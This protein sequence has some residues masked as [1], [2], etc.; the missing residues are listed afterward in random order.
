MNQGVESLADSEVLSRLPQLRQVERESMAAVI[1]H[2]AVVDA[3]QLYAEAGFSSMFAYLTRGLGYSEEAAMRRLKVARLVHR[4]PQVHAALDRE[5]PN[6]A[7]PGLP[8]GAL[9]ALLGA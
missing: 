8:I 1:S 4:F 9:A 7:A 3:R 2:V 6:L 5:T